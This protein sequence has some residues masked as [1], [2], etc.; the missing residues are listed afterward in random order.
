MAL[1]RRKDSNVW[2]VDISL[3]GQPRVR[4]STGTADKAEAR[5]IEAATTQALAANRYSNPHKNWA[6]AVS[7]W[8]AVE[9]RSESEK[10]SLRKLDRYFPDK[11][12]RSITGTD[13][14]QALSFCRTAGTYTRYRT[15][16]VA[17]LNLAK[18]RKWLAEVPDI[19][20]RKDKKPKSRRWLTHEEWDRLYAALPQH[21]KGPAMVAVQTGLRQANVFGLRWKNVDLG[22]R[23]V[24]VLAEDAKAGAG[25]PVPLNDAALAAIQAEIGKHHEFVFAYRG[26]P[27]AKPKEGFAQAKRDS[28]LPGFTWHGLRHTW[29]T[30]HIQNGTPVDVLQKLGGWS[31]MRMVMTYAHHTAGHLAKYAGNTGESK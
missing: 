21:L 26:R 15:M 3:P 10:L 24:V 8:L 23:H 17:I 5:R 22:R 14:E 20:Q 6:D 4:E 28:G 19:P 1:Y 29:A 18:R 7:T 11:A 16:I 12:L 30:W 13:V 25:I 9:P 27:M 31:D 2:W